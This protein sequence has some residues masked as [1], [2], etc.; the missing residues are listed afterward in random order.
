MKTFRHLFTTHVQMPILKLKPK[1]KKTDFTN[2]VS[3]IFCYSLPK[4]Y[5]WQWVRKKT[6]IVVIKFSKWIN[7]KRKITVESDTVK[8]ANCY[9]HDDCWIQ[10]LAVK[11]LQ[12]V[13]ETTYSQKNQRQLWHIFTKTVIKTNKGQWHFL[14]SKHIHWGSAKS[15]TEFSQFNLWQHLMSRHAYII[16]NPQYIKNTCF[17]RDNVHPHQIC[18]VNVANVD[19]S[20][21]RYKIYRGILIANMST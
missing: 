12:T 6:I 21:K 13:Q 14:F 15:R 2:N 18:L 1:E 4:W 8:I 9:C 10:H 5:L 7:E 3:N 19:F 16:T 11:I 17:E 20:Y